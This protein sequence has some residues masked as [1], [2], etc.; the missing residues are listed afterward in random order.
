MNKYEFLNELRRELAFLPQEELGDA[1]DYYEEYI[2]ESDDE[3][4]A[5]RELGTPKRIAED[6]R[7]E[8]YEKTSSDNPLPAKVAQ[9]TQSESE[10][11]RPI[12]FYVLLVV[13][14]VGF[15]VPLLRFL[16]EAASSILSL[17]ALVIIALLLIKALKRNDKKDIVYSA[18]V[19]TCSDIRSLDIRLGAG[20]FVI[21]QGNGFKIDGGSLKSS[22]NNGIWQISGNI[23]DNISSANPRIITITVPEYFTAENA[24]VRLGAGN[25]LIKGL[26]AYE[27]SLEVSVGNMEAAGLYSKKLDIK[28]GVGR[29][30]ADA[31]LHG[32]V[33]VSCGMGDTTLRFTNR[34]E[35]F[36]RKASI[37]MGK[38]YIGGQ[39]INGSG[40]TFS[41]GGAPYNMN[42][43]C[44]MGN[45]R[46]DFGGIV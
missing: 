4:T 43:K 7:R 24:R 36:N 1:I 39:E 5:L 19:Q 45:V 44:G 9:N 29:M 27:M 35:E 12:W 10:I 20:M 26:S 6:I 8:Y 2:S 16:G 37:G 33:N 40:Q 15:G 34:A 17:L 42:I 31:S 32:D 41:E 28:C 25:L 23:T 13:L 38:V 14:A 22:I 46:I 18:D 30:K 3:E 11:K 21:E